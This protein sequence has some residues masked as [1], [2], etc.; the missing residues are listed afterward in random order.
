MQHDTPADG[1]DIMITVQL[2]VRG[3]YIPTQEFRRRR[4]PFH[5]PLNEK[6]NWR[7]GY[8]CIVDDIGYRVIDI[9]KI[10][11]KDITAWVDVEWVDYGPRGRKVPLE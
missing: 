11:D 4:P 7:E 1:D 3:T 2:I 10:N 9:K 6:L 5:I 8:A